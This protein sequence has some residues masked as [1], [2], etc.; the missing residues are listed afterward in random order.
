MH[1]D[2][3]LANTTIYVDRN[4]TNV[5]MYYYAVSAVNAFG[6]GARSTTAAG[7][8]GSEPSA[9]TEFAALGD[10]QTI[11][12]RWE[13]P[14]DS[15]IR[16]VTSYVL[17]R[18]NDSGPQ[19]SFPMGLQTEKDDRLDR[20]ESEIFYNVTALNE[21][22]ESEPSRTV[23][24]LAPS[25]PMQ[26]EGFFGPGGAQLHW[27]APFSDGGCNISFYRIYR[28]FNSEDFKTIGGT[29][30][31]WM[32]FTDPA[33]T[34]SSHAL[35]RVTA[36]NAVGEGLP[37]PAVSISPDLTIPV[38]YIE[39]PGDGQFFNRT[40][41]DFKGMAS[42]PVGIDRV[43]ISCEPDAW[44][45][46]KGTEKWNVSVLLNEGMHNISVRA[47]DFAE[48]QNFTRI[49]I[50][51]DLTA[52]VLRFTSPPNESVVASEVIN[53]SATAEDANRIM[54]VEFSVGGKSWS[55]STAKANWS[56]T[57]KLKPGANRIYARTED[58]AGNTNE[59]GITVIL[60]AQDPQI[61]IASP[62]EWSYIK[63]G[64]PVSVEGVASDDVGIRSVEI[65]VDDGDWSTVN[66]TG[67]WSCVINAGPGNHLIQAKATDLVGRQSVATANITTARPVNS[68]IFPGQT[69]LPQ[70]AAV[71]AL[72][73]VVVVLMLAWRSG[74]HFW[75]T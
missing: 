26:L 74:R 62:L 8:P 73:I 58:I 24:L 2:V 7:S 36:G 65:R 49:Q 41:I 67:N 44:V 70:A 40:D 59:T 15:G 69:L 27:I 50:V 46:C 42:D 68:S 51:V 61:S 1:P 71:V 28:S 29:V 30:A 35:Y 12:L 53:V 13:P 23:Q 54:G 21:F 63:A 48:N 10:G 43:E 4:V 39:S 3:T 19:L 37:C 18:W 25:V 9:P 56:A 64:H 20:S 17:H 6:E 66:G 14:A 45:L 72:A 38:V 52:P 47:T 11:H 75:K 57:L 16:Q 32:N 31:N 34:Y 60:D 55:Q 5:T 33:A 22:G